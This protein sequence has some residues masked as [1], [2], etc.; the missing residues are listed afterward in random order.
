MEARK[1]TAKQLEGGAPLVQNAF[2]SLRLHKAY[3]VILFTRT[4]QPFQA[5]AEIDLCTSELSKALPR[6][7]RNGIRVVL[8]MRQG[9]IRVHPA[10]DPAFERFRKETQ[11]GFARTAVVVTTPLGRVRADRLANADGSPMRIVGS[12]EEAVDFING[13]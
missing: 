6:A 3:Q 5:A 7:A 1:V 10:L 9:P 11:A 4:S 8:D 12:M 2:Y 13:G